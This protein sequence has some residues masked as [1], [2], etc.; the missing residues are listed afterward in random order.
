MSYN[1]LVVGGGIAGMESAVTLGDMGY[2]VL[3]VEKTASIGGKMILLSKVFP[4]LDCSSCICTPK[5]AATANHPNVAVMTYSE[6]DGITQQEDGTF[7]VGL[8]RK[9]TFVD[10]AACTGCA[11]CEVVCSVALPDQFNF[12]LSARRAAHIPFPQAVPK[13][14]L[15]DRH[16]TSPC[17]FECPAG[18][19][20]HGYVSL[21][22]AGKYDE[23]FRLHLEDAPLPGSL[24]RACYAFCETGCTRGEL[25]GTVPIREI[26]RF[27][28]DRYYERYPEPEPEPPRELLDQKVAVVGSGPAGL[29]AAFHLARR[30]YRVSV[31]ESADLPGGLL[32]YGV[33]DSR[34]PNSVVERDIMNVTALGVTIHTR[35]TVT[36]LASLKD[37]GFDAVF[38]ALGAMEAWKAGVPGEE[39]EGV[40]D[41]TTFIRQINGRGKVD[42]SSKAVLVA[43]AAGVA[44]DVAKM[45]LRLGAE[46]VIAQYRDHAA[47]LG[48]RQR[49]GRGGAPDGQDP[50]TVHRQKRTPDRGGEP[51]PRA[52]RTG[53]WR[54]AAHASGGLRGGR[55]PGPRHPHHRHAPG[56]RAPGRGADGQPGRH[57]LRGPG[58][59]ADL[60]ALGLRGG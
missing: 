56:H 4:T 59:V 12:D 6:V 13:K 31:F 30:G 48:G 9:P 10:S 32:R 53:P 34:L 23:A 50:R 24:S 15:I 35:T 21:V 36:S 52:A 41:L 38:L 57:R 29:C 40:V 44:V 3:L 54:R 16:G 11:K 60:H 47:G 7:R 8:L 33:P 5:M 14:A 18:V 49:P 45:A 58:D 28:V 2:K 17:T 20:A 37:Q 25:E 19:K 26:K 43:G 1:I 39:L 22:R 27:L 46:R 55:P 51:R 42:L